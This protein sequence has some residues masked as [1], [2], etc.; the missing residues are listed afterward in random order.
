MKNNRVLLVILI[1][2]VLAVCC[3][4]AAIGGVIVARNVGRSVDWM[5]S[6]NNEVTDTNGYT[7]DVGTPATLSVDLPVGSVTVRTGETG[8]IIVEATRRAWG[9]ND[10]DARQRLER[11]TVAVAQDATGVTVH[12]TGQDWQGGG[13]VAPR[14]PQVDLLITVP[15]ETQLDITQGV[16]R[17]D[18]NSVRGDV[19]I[20]AD[21]GEVML[22]DILPLATLEV[23]SRVASIDFEGALTPGASYRLTSDVGRI[24]LR[25]PQ[26][27]AFRVDARSDIG[28]A[29]VDFEV[30]GESQREGFTGKEITGQVGENTDTQLTLHSRVG[31]IRVSRLP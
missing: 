3:F 19:R 28:D 6:A 10:A 16:G 20:T 25:L 22:R 30:V 2:V 5:G 7:F 11:M 12:V 1:L 29:T 4:S 26:D 31:E 17:V 13:E 8:R 14:S 15:E 9:R 24:T 23:E 27:S 18:V 21:V